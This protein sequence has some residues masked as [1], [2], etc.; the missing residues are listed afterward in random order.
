[1]LPQQE[2]KKKKKKLRKKSLRMC[3]GGEA[4]AAAAGKFLFFTIC[5]VLVFLSAAWIR[6]HGALVR[7]FCEVE[8]YVREKRKRDT[9]YSKRGGFITPHPE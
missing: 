5:A 4:A 1:M 7:L 8:V 6:R 3:G 2:E 9:L